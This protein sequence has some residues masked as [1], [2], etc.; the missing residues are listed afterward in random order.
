MAYNKTTSKAKKKK[1]SKCGKIHSGSCKG[2]K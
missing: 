1:C 2:K